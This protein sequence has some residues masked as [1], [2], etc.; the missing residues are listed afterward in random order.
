MDKGSGRSRQLSNHRR[1]HPRENEWKKMVKRWLRPNAKRRQRRSAERNRL[2]IPGR[3]PG[4]PGRRQ[5]GES[6]QGGALKTRARWKATPTQ[7]KE[8]IAQEDYPTIKPWLEQLQQALPMPRR[9]LVYQQAGAAA[10]GP[11]ANGTGD[12]A[13]RRQWRRGWDGV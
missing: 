8:A 1:L 6:H 10:D 5:P 9:C 2:R 11:Q 3:N 4:V 7:L 12:K 13:A